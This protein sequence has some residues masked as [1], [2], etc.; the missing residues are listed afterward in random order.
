M[1]FD[2][3]TLFVG[4]LPNYCS[5]YDLRPL[6]SSFGPVLDLQVHNGVE[7]GRS[8]S[9]AFVTLTNFAA[10]EAARKLLDGHAFMGRKLRYV[11]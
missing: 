3:R 2:C 7:T 11:S 1:N 4:D 10:I 8:S 6:F 5:E 9:Y